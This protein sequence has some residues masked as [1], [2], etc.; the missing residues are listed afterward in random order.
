MSNRFSTDRPGN[1][2]ATTVQATTARLLTPIQ[3]CSALNVGRTRLYELLA[4][5]EIQSVT[6]GRSRRIPLRAL[7]DYVAA[8]SAG[9]ESAR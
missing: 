7:D 5:G 2:E 6:I 3:A 4:S 8:L 1:E 9:K